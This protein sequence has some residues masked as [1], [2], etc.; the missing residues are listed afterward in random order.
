MNERF[1]LN[2]ENIPYQSLFEYIAAS[3]KKTAPSIKVTP[4]MAAMAWRFEKLRSVLIGSYPKLTKETANTSMNKWHYNN[5][6][7]INAIECH[8]IPVKD[9]CHQWAEEFERSFGS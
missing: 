3:M 7:I 8:F 5:S 4:L 6:K 1:I 2:S 9:S